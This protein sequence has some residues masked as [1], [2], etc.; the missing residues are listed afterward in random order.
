MVA[1]GVVGLLAACGGS[2]TTAASTVRTSTA[3]GAPSAPV[4]A[5]ATGSQ[6]TACDLITPDVI[7]A[8]D[9]TY[10]VVRQTRSSGLGKNG[11]SACTYGGDP[12]T[13]H[14]R[15][16]FLVLLI[17]T[18]AALKAQHTTAVKEAK[19]NA[20]PCPADAVR[21]FGPG[22]GI[23]SYLYFCVKPDHAPD[24]GWVQGSNLHV[25]EVGSPDVDYGT[26]KDRETEFEAVARAIS[27]NVGR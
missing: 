10:R 11:T 25:L 12:D 27:T 23:G 2:P 6:K 16:N 19:A 3:H 20:S 1:V 21:E 15:S 26:T 4:T 5:V 13:T 22:E 7:N 14:I 17:L 9:F 8:A 24:G 18:P